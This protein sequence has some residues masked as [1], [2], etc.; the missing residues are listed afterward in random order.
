MGLTRSR[1]PIQLEARRPPA[2]EPIPTSGSESGP[3]KPPLGAT[4]AAIPPPPSPTHDRDGRRNRARC[5][6][7]GGPAKTDWPGDTAVSSTGHPESTILGP[8]QAP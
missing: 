6:R 3:E 2:E 7:R 1:S 5:F 8:S 4:N